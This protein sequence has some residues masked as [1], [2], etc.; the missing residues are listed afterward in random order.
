MTDDLRAPTDRVLRLVEAAQRLAD[1]ADPLGQRARRIL[2][3][4][5]GL[6]PEGVELALGQCL[7]VRPSAEEVRRLCASVPPARCCHVLLSANVFVA[8][9][10][11]IALALAASASV[12][13]R[14]S[15]REPNM[16]R[17]LHDASRGVIR[18]V[19]E[20][21]P[22]PGDQVWAY[23][24]DTTLSKLRAELPAGVVFRGHGSG[25][26]AA[27]VGPPPDRRTDS[28]RTLQLAER[29]A[30]DTVLFDQ[31]GCLS[32][33]VVLT[34][35]SEFAAELAE[36]LRAALANFERTVP[37]GVVSD[38]ERALAHRYRDTMLYAAEVTA[39]GKGWVG[40]DLAGETLLVPPVGRLLH[41]C[42]VRDPVEALR[43]L[44]QALT[45]IGFEGSPE[46]AHRLAESFPHARLAGI[47]R[48]QQPPFDG[49]VDRRPGTAAELL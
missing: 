7:E 11:A 40:L 37:R 13:V 48:M 29:L 1:P 14:P 3:G 25:L 35:D 28:E 47:G 12:N 42:N 30:R 27:V 49:P 39:A 41:V 31:R 17:L 44:A 32:P 5:T 24:C 23:G 4:S 10:R 15:R 2:P 34:S 9:H 45:T 36:A 6:S 43:P 38:E 26:G 18:I 16:V 33:R 22:L 20:L 46:L 19:E 8:S 21:C